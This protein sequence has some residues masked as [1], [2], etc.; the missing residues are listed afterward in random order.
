MD[1]KPPHCPKLMFLQFGLLYSPAEEFQADSKTNHVDESAFENLQSVS[2]Q[3]LAL[4][5]LTSGYQ[6]YFP[7]SYGSSSSQIMSSD[8][9]FSLI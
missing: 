9:V 4:Q 7:V 5:S 8:V 2:S 6:Q 1:D 3:I